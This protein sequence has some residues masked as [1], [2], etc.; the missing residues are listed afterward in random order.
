MAELVVSGISTVS[1]PSGVSSCSTTVQNLIDQTRRLLMTVHRDQITRLDGSISDSTEVVTLETT[2][3]QLQ[4]GAKLGIDLE[5]IG[6][7]TASGLATSA[8]IRGDNGSTAA[9]HGDNTKVYLNPKF[10]G[11]EIHQALTQEL[12][13]LSALGLHRVRLTT[14]LTYS[15]ATEGYDLTGATDLIGIKR[16]YWQD[17]VG[18]DWIPVDS[19]SLQRDHAT[20]D[21][22]S[23]YA[24]RLTSGEVGPG[25]AVRVAYAAPFG[26]LSSTLSDNV[27]ST[28]GLWCQAHDLLPLGAAL[29]LAWPTEISRNFTTG[30]PES[31]RMEEV[32]A[33]AQANSV[34]GI[35]ALRE[36][37]VMEEQAR[38]AAW[39]PPRRKRYLY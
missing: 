31:R 16:V 14:D 39:Y 2:A 7:L 12:H 30:Q 19:Y 23:S 6:V 29:R 27:Q 17:Y 28:T 26:T 37:R 1:A 15:A 33:G 25:R 9:A 22:A 21:Y 38:F 20:A 35:V 10:S 11:F 5:E 32:P 4:T 13:G 24:L 8:V 18:S 36:R 34:R 3:N